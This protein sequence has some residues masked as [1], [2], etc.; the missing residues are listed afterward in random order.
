MQLQILFPQ[1]I[2]DLGD[3]ELFTIGNRND[4]LMVRE[5]FTD[6]VPETKAV[7]P[8]DCRKLF[9]VPHGTFVYPLLIKS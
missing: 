1:K 4:P 2:E 9:F 7:D 8:K 3:G 6:A 5:H